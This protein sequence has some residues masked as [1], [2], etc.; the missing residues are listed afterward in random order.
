MCFYYVI[1]NSS[2]NLATSRARGPRIGLRINRRQG[3]LNNHHLP[4]TGL[5]ITTR[6][7]CL[8][9][10]TSIRW[11]KSPKQSLPQQQPQNLGISIMDMNPPCHVRVAG[12][13]RILNQIVYAS[14]VFLQAL[15]STRTCMSEEHHYLEGEFIPE[16]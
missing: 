13:L 4:L 11:Y 2:R 9:R 16:N 5:E 8:R 3:P 1:N 12:V 14:Y 6:P 7:S 15:L 10:F